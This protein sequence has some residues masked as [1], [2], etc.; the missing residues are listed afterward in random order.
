MKKILIIDDE[1]PIVE[2]LNDKFIREGFEVLV[3]RTAKEGWEKIETKKPDLTLLNIFMPGALGWETLEKIKT[4]P[5]S[6]INSL[7][8]I[9][10]S[11]MGGVKDIKRAKEMGAV[12]FIVKANFSLKEIVQKI[13][14]ALNLNQ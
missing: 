1:K 12:D 10:F 6:E 11:N 5:S 3:A 4:H 14:D 13:R 2:A 7:P 8:V 9:I